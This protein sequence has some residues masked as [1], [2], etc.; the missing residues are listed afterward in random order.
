MV[1]FGFET[2]ISGTNLVGNWKQWE[3]VELVTFAFETIISGTGN[4]HQW[5]AVEL[6]IIVLETTSRTST[7]GNFEVGKHQDK[8]EKQREAM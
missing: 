3:A 2:I 7:G 4:G 8:L 1:T 6:V 5:E